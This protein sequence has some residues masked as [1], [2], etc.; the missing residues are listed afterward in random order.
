MNATL[1]IA[2]MVIAISGLFDTVTH[3]SFKFAADRVGIDVTGL[4]SALRFGWQ[5]LRTRAAWFAIASSVLSLL[6]FMFALTLSDLSFAF[7][8]DSIH[9]V[10]IA[11]AAMYYLKERVTGQRWL[12]TLIIM[13]GITLVAMSGTG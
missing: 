1:W 3:V 7:S 5:F 8:V 4:P 6:L 11:V 2:L 10:F 9:H 12:G 13:L